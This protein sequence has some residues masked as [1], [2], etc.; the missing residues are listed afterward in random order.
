MKTFDVFYD[1]FIDS[2]TTW[3]MFAWMDEN[4]KHWYR[5]DPKR[6]DTYCFANEMDAM[7]FKL[8]WG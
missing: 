3:E 7:A 6:C 1:C 8:K 5:I 4:I 2:K